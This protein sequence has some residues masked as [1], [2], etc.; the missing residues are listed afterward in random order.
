MTGMIHQTATG[1]LQ[2]RLRLK[3]RSTTTVRSL[4]V[5]HDT[6][7]N[8]SP[9]LPRLRNWPPSPSPEYGE[10][11]DDGDSKSPLVVFRPR[12]AGFQQHMA[13]RLTSSPSGSRIPRPSAIETF[14]IDLPHTPRKPSQELQ[15]RNTENLDSGCLEGV[16]DDSKAADGSSKI[17][18]ASDDRSLLA[19]RVRDL[20]LDDQAPD[21][22]CRW[23]SLSRSNTSAERVDR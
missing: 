18:E 21:E 6:A 17:I 1:M 20:H 15:E 9:A 5:W 22:S 14:N 4:G 10:S 23:A 16:P 12:L 8:V 3:H 19:Q 2:S 7:A 13:D 11:E